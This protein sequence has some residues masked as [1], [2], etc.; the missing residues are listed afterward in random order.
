MNEFFEFLVKNKPVARFFGILLTGVPLLYLLA[1]GCRAEFN[2]NVIT[3]YLFDWFQVGSSFMFLVG[4][5]MLGMGF[6]ND[7]NKKN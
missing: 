3:R 5:I 1:G 7:K 4:L 6:L 2:G